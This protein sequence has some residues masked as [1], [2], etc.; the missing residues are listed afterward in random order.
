MK[1]PNAFVLGNEFEP[2]LEST[3]WFEENDN[4]IR[5]R[6]LHVTRPR[7]F[8]AEHVDELYTWLPC[9]PRAPWSVQNFS[10]TFPSHTAPGRSTPIKR[11]FSASSST[12]SCTTAKPETNSLSGSRAS[13]APRAPS[14]K[15]WTAFKT[16]LPPRQRAASTCVEAMSGRRT[17]GSDAAGWLRR[18]SCRSPSSRAPPVG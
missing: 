9:H 1:V 7:S 16:G 17:P 6:Y 2:L 13:R 14:F 8:W 5:S 4:K 11:A 15:T 10:R 18:S 12:R 3:G